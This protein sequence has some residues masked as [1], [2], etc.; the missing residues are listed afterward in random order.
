M[1]DVEE[2]VKK[3]D[4]VLAPR[5]GCCNRLKRYWRRF[6]HDPER[7]RN[8]KHRVN[9]QMTLLNAFQARHI[10][11]DT[12][13]IKEHTEKLVRIERNQEEQ[14]ILNWLTPQDYAPQ[15]HEILRTCKSGTGRWFLESEEYKSWLNHKASTLFC[16]GHPGAGKTVLTSIVINE[17][18]TKFS[19]DAQTAIVYVYCNYKRQNEQTL[20]A[21]LSSILKQLLERMSQLPESIKTLYQKCLFKKTWLSVDEHLSLIESVIV[22]FSRVFVLVDALDEC[23]IKDNTQG[24]FV[25]KLTS[26]QS[27]S[28]INLLFTS[29]F[30]PE[31]VNRFKGALRREVRADERDVKKYIESRMNEL[32]LF[33]R[34]NADLKEDI[35]LALLRSVDGM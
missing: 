28:E 16:P 10:K 25:N 17:L 4:A 14:R 3:A 33:A 15:Q 26:L 20:E 32:P 12:S 30:M 35:S 22:Q 29:R 6:R 27:V 8:L 23:R 31:I 24:S 9:D 34:N 5:R 2:V 18:T 19:D 7:T 21:L 1:A 13:T 11:T